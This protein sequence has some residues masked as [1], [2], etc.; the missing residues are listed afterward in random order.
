M[1]ITV[2]ETTLVNVVASDGAQ[3][4]ILL[5]RPRNPHGWLV[6][7]H[8]GS[9]QYG[10]ARQW[11]PITARLA[12]LSGWAV[13]SVEYRLAPAH[14][15]PA[16]VLDMLAA[17]G[18]AETVTDGLPVVVG[19]DSAGGTIAASAA[20]AR[21]DTGQAVPP[22]MLA[23][24]P[25]DPRCASPSYSAVPGA[26]PNRADLRAAWRLWLGA[27]TFHPAI[28]PTPMAASGLA[29]LALVSVIV[30]DAD[31]VRDDA[32]TY[33]DRLDADGVPVALQV[34]PE[35]GHADLLAPRSRVLPAV[36]AALSAPSLSERSTMSHQA[37]LLE[38]TPS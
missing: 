12:S 4:P 5:H 16:A 24:P 26:F 6:W 1:T 21:R 31:P 36:V 15:F 23:Y 9:W 28:L 19:G 17:L 38:G 33:A 37:T 29:G 34:L 22:Q 11:A 30:G 27:G 14:R 8:G 25:L 7:A 2:P 32:I 10:S 13:A 20:L 35:V 3:V 18:W